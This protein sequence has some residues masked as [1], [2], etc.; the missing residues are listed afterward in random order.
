MKFKHFVLCIG[1]AGFLLSCEHARL[2]FAG[3]PDT[4]YHKKL[5]K[6]TQYQKFFGLEKTLFET[7]VTYMTPDLNEAYLDRYQKQFSPTP[8]EF[9]R[10]ALE[11]QNELAMFEIFYVAHYASD[12]DNQSLAETRDYKKVWNF[13]LQTSRDGLL[14]SSDRITPMPLTTQ[15][16]YFFPQLDGWN[17]FYKITFPKQAD[18]GYRKLV[19]KGIVKELQFEWK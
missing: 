12:D 2:T 16:R 5:Y 19:M 7:S 18:T 1:F 10:I 11:M 6:L 13:L 14:L 4:P 8:D 9:N 3:A 17:R 15:A